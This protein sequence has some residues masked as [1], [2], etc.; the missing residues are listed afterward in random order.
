MLIAAVVSVSAITRDPAT[1]QRTRGIVSGRPLLAGGDGCF[2]LLAQAVDVS[3][4]AAVRARA[5]P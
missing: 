5:S 1:T 2:Q 3:L 4:G